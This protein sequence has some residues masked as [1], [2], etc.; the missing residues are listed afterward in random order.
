MK[1]QDWGGRILSRQQ[2]EYLHL[3]GSAGW[4]GMKNPGCARQCV[5][6]GRPRACVHVVMRY[7]VA[8]ESIWG[9]AGARTSRV[10][11]GCKAVGGQSAKLCS[12][13]GCQYVRLNRCVWLS[14]CARW[15][16]CPS[17]WMN[18]TV[19][20]HS[21]VNVGKHR[22]VLESTGVCMCARPYV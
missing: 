1:V 15:C 18:K 8:Y 11:W 9:R 10:E 7:S 5:H 13:Q 19:S 2:Y 16:E 3:W 12:R 20:L 14:C 4:W 22:A 6:R 17:S 21:R